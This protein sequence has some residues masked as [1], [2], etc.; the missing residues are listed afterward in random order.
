MI[1]WVIQTHLSVT[2]VALEDL[3]EMA[4]AHSAFLLGCREFFNDLLLPCELIHLD[5]IIICCFGIGSFDNFLDLLNAVWILKLWKNLLKLSRRFNANVSWIPF[6]CLLGQ[7]SDSCVIVALLSSFKLIC[8]APPLEASI[9]DDS[10][11]IPVNLIQF[12]FHMK[13]KAF[14]HTIRRISWYRHSSLL[15]GRR[16]GSESSTAREW[17]CCSN[18][19]CIRVVRG[20]LVVSIHSS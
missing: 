11:C 13:D 1:S 20:L 19:S 18:N 14:P 4:T 10:Y 17:F 12:E 15:F 2:H 7:L 8:G 9:W 16:M 6:R 3:R 5:I